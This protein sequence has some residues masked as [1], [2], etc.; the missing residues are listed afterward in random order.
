MAFIQ[1]FIPAIGNELLEF[2][3]QMLIEQSKLSGPVLF[4][5]IDSVT[6]EPVVARGKP[7]LQDWLW[8]RIPGAP[9]DEANR[10]RLHPVRQPPLDHGILLPWIEDL[11]LR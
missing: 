7:A 10:S 4:L 3:V 2:G 8:N 11:N 1:M 5:R 9:G 6:N